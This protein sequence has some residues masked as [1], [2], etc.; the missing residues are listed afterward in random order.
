MPTV[1]HFCYN[2]TETSRIKKPL[3]IGVMHTM[4]RSKKVEEKVI[5]ESVIFIDTTENVS[6]KITDDEIAERAILS[7]KI[8]YELEKKKAELDLL[9]KDWKAQIDEIAAKLKHLQ[10]VVETGE[11]FRSVECKRA[12]DVERGITWI[13]FEGKQYH[14]R[15][16]TA[17]ELELIRTQTLDDMM[18]EPAGSFEDD[19]EDSF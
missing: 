6:I 13:E 9:K 15:A 7:C 17:K 3:P 2:P 14:E 16:A 19:D 4:A 11:E 10:T 8:A 1:S 18:P 12:F 5:K